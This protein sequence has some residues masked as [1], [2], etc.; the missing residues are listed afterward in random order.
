MQQFE[1]GVSGRVSISTRAVL[2]ASL[3]C[4]PNTRVTMDC[5]CGAHDMTDM[6][7]LAKK[8]GP[9]ITIG[10]LLSRYRCRWCRGV[11]VKW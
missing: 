7:W 2:A 8:L 9:A 3:D 5:R 6:A 4:F 11:D 10:G 1:E